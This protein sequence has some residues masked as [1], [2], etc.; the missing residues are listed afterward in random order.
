MVDMHCSAELA[1]DPLYI[2]LVSSNWYICW[3]ALMSCRCVRGSQVM[4]VCVLKQAVHW[5]GNVP[6]LDT[7]TS[8]DRSGMTDSETTAFPSN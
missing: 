4:R 8:M 2:V 5:L 1:R 3:K 7:T 6:H